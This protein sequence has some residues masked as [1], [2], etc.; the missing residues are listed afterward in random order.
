[1]P[2]SPVVIDAEIVVCDGDGKSDFK[3]VIEGVAK[4]L[5]KALNK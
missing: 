3:A 2:T 1:M 5:N 4:A